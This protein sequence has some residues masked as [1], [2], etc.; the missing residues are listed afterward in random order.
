MR[1]SIW[2]KRIP[3]ILGILMIVVG[4]GITSY[5]VKSGVFFITKASPDNTPRQVRITNLSDSSFS[6]SYSTTQ[7]VTGVISFGVS[8]DN[9]K[10]TVLDDR[11]QQGGNVGLYNL[12][13]ITLKDLKPST[14][15][16]FSITSGKDT[17]LNNNAPFQVATGPSLSS[18]PPSQNPITGRLVTPNGQSP[19]EALI[20]VTTNGAQTLSALADKNG[21]Y[22]LPIN[23]IRSDNL[24]SYVSVSPGTIFNMLALDGGSET[25]NAPFYISQ[26]N[27]VPLVILSKN[28]DF[29]SGIS[30]S[31]SSSASANTHFPSFP[32]S[33]SGSQIKVGIT[34]PKKNEAFTDQKPAFSGTASPSAKVKIVIHSTPIE[35]QVV[36]DANGNWTFR[37]NQDLAPGNH[38]IS[39]TTRDKSGILRTITQQFTVYA[40]G[41]QIQGSAIISPT[42][43]SILTPTPTPAP[44]PIVPTASPTAVLTPTLAP[45]AIVIM[46]PTPSPAVI[47]KASKLPVTGSNQAILIGVSGIVTTVAGAVL[48]LLSRGGI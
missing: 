27:P 20:Y 3:S 41:T 39:I 5:L 22:V 16:Y 21:N 36:A 18:V 12:H 32:V 30:P 40:A 37:P 19:Q 28:Y 26:A 44:T 34:V 6:V 46:T 23:A 38:T 10:Y 43:T 14:T 35:T 33:I 29:T 1:L 24:D 45:T 17:F 2:Q 25:S 42:P 11:D 48:F 47:T 15:Y 13:H 31:A 4:I 7:R 9:L 8:R